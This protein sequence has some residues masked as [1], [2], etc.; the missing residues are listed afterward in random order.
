VARRG[1]ASGSCHVYN[2]GGATCRSSGDGRAR[3]ER[4]AFGSSGGAARELEGKLNRC[5]WTTI[6][7]D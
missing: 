6:F 5:G 2:G 1:E 7:V 3:R 4:E